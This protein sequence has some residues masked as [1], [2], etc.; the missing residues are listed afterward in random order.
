[1]NRPR[2]GLPAEPAVTPYGSGRLGTGPATERVAA[3]PGSAP[4]RPHT[5]F[6]GDN[7]P[8]IHLCP[9]AMTVLPEVTDE[10]EVDERTRRDGDLAVD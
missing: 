8:L 6:A 10:Q 5:G 9:A 3:G 7:S 2:G 4:R 1:M